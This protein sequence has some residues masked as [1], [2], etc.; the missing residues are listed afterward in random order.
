MDSIEKELENEIQNSG[1]SISNEAPVEFQDTPQEFSAPATSLEGI[2]PDFVLSPS[3][4]ETNTEPATEPATEP[5]ATEQ[6]VD[7]PVQTE[8][9]VQESSLNTETPV[10]SEKDFNIDEAV[11]GYLSETLG[12]NLESIDQLKSSMSQQ[13]A[14][15]DE[16]V[17]VIADFVEK[18]GRS[19]EDWFKYQAINPS[20]MDDLTAI[21]MSM[22]SEY[23]ELNGEEIEMLVGSKYKL[24]ED[25]Y[26]D[27]EIKLSK[28]QLKI[29]ANK[30]RQS[31]EQL[32]NSYTMPEV[33][34]TQAVQSPIDENWIK[35]MT[36]ETNALEAL[37]FELPGGEFNFGIT[38]EYKNQ[39]IDKNSNI[40]T[41]FDQYISQDGQWDYD[42]FN[43]HRAV[44]DN[45]DAIAK[46]IYQQ[47]LSD[48]QREIVDQAANVSTKSPNVG[49]GKNNT[50]NLERQILEALNVDK[51]LKFL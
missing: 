20:E 1:F 33:K 6:V 15:V 35:S 13:Q 45:I 23:P 37:T 4:E 51:T 50:N 8:T 17:K 48:G 10:E 44:V 34:E 11:L 18:T 29:E 42:T 19:P 2:E 46:N 38:D 43:T 24:D 12:V 31:I 21:K 41:Y 7:E 30:S 26:T 32:R 16:R 27:D 9:P 3:N 25:L 40:E 22:T 28:L 36:E 39:L 5:T 14:E 47:G 49:A